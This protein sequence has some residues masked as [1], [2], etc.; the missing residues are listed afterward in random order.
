MSVRPPRALAAKARL[1]DDPLTQA[2]RQEIVAEQAATHA[3]LVRRLEQAL[4]ALEAVRHTQGRDEERRLDAAGEALW[5][6]VVQRELCGFG[7]TERFLR[8]LNVPPAV[9]LRMGPRRR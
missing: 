3:R 6:L 2:L 7:H 9:W 1:P 4:A 8:H 5:Q